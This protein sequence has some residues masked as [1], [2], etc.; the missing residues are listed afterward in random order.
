M[1]AFRQ[2]PPDNFLSHHHR[3]VGR[4]RTD[5]RDGLPALGLDFASRVTLD[6]FRIRRHALLVLFH[7]ALG[8]FFGLCQERLCVFGC[9]RQLGFVFLQPALGFG[10]VAFRLIETV[11]NLFLAL[12]QHAQQDGKCILVEQEEQDPKGENLPEDQG[13]K[14]M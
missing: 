6:A 3:Q 10:T 4:L 9:R 11:L 2:C 8:A 12:F 5:V 14:E 13:R 1:I 7:Q